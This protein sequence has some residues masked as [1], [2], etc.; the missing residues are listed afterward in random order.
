MFP[1]LTEGMSRMPQFQYVEKSESLFSQ[2]RWGSE[3]FRLARKYRENTPVPHIFLHDFLDTDTVR[4]MAHEFPAPHT[5]AWT[6]YKHQNENKLGLNKRLLFPP[7]LGKVTDELNSPEFV[8][9][10]SELTGIPELVADPSLEG[11]GLH[12]SSK[13]GFL[14]VHTDFSMHHY[15]RNWGR[16]VNL[17]VYLN[18]GW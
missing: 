18:E 1:N 6:Q 2:A 12:Q 4:A 17:I 16:R 7:T 10:L 8:E 9:W 3:L 15:H 11:G 13:G 14:N 5:D